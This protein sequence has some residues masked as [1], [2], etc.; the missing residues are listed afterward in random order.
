MSAPTN[1]NPP[2]SPGNLIKMVAKREITTKLHD[3]TYLISI[4]VFIAIILV[5][6]GFNVLANSGNDEYKVG[7]VGSQSKE[8][9]AQVAEGAKQLGAKV[10]LSTV[11]DEDA[12]KPKLENGD[13]DA[14]VS[15]DT[16]ITKDSLNAT[17]GAVLKGAYAAEQQQKQIADSGIDQQKLA[18]AMKVVPMHEKTIDPNAK[19]NMERGIVAIVAVGIVYG[20]LMMIGQFVAQGVV[21]EKSSRVIELLMVVVK[22]WQLLTGKIIGLGILGLMQLVIVVGLG[23]GGA[24]AAD[25]ITV[26]GSAIS[27]ILQ[28]LAWFVLGYTFFASMFA[29]AA[30]LVSRQEDLGS[31]MIPGTFIP[32]L[33]FFAAF[34]VLDDPSG[35]FA[36]I[37]SMIPGVSPTTMPVR[38]AMSDVPV[39]QYAIAVVLQVIAI[40]LLV[41][42][43]GRVYA[44]AMLKTSGKLK[45]KDALAQS[46]ETLAATNAR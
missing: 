17:L 13:L 1:P 12:A 32:M 46:K 25:L 21:E 23:L 5:V 22:P 42:L 33:S 30:S 39:Y 24:I 11:K 19:T 34:K 31:A 29:L 20:M 8:F 28:V 26:P 38:A 18:E 14:I 16:L 10:T 41:R 27:T 40:V 36:T 6:V 35:T 43:A 44:G 2:A 45:I 15:G 7:V 3:K 37:V 9:T 4:G